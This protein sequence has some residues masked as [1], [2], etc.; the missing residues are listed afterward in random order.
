MDIHQK[1]FGA[2]PI[3]LGVRYR[4]VDVGSDDVGLQ[5]LWRLVGHL[6]PI[7]QHRDRE[8]VARQPHPEVWVGRVGVKL[9]ANLLERGHPGDSEVAVLEDHPGAFLLC[10]LEH[11]DG[12]GALAL[13]EGEGA[14]LGPTKPLYRA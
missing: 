11:L 7:L 2:S 9:L 13:P 1:W 6:H 3:E 4:V 8:G 5:T 12:D 10:S 14:Q